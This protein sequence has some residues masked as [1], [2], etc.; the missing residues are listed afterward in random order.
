MLGVSTGLPAVWCT[1]AYGLLLYE[2]SLLQGQLQATALSTP[3]LQRAVAARADLGVPLADRV[4]FHG[5]LCSMDL[6]GAPT[7]LCVLW[8]AIHPQW[9]RK[10]LMLFGTKQQATPDSSALPLPVPVDPMSSDA[11]CAAGRAMR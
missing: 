6:V 9:S 3:Q 10:L 11:T 7:A 2:L 4:C 1:L 8:L 5:V